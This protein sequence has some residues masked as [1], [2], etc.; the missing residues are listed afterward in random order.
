MSLRVIVGDTR[1]EVLNVW[2]DALRTVSGFEF[3]SLDTERFCALPDLDALLILSAAAHHHDGAPFE[4]GTSQV[5]SA[6]PELP[7][8]KRVVTTPPMP[9]QLRVNQWGHMDAVPSKHRSPAEGAYLE[10]R[11]IFRAV[12]TFNAEGANRGIGTLGVHLELINAPLGDARTEA[13]AVK[14]AYL[15]EIGKA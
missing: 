13:E 12:R 3:R 1:P 11:E 8:V 7:H 14:R 9:A 4:P 6:P 2:R 15:E 10:F 5:L